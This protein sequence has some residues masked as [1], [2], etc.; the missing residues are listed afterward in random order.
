MSTGFYLLD[1]PNP[2]G[3]NYYTS[4]NGPILAQI[5]HITAGLQDLELVDPDSSAERTA[6]YAATTTRDVSW[7]S[8]S[9]TDGFLR[10]LPP[11]Y[12]AWQCI[13]YNSITL[14]HEISKA[15][16]D[17]RK[18][19]PTWILRTLT[20]AANA[21]RPDLTKYR[22]PIRKATRAELDR[23]RATDGPP[24]GLI[25]HHELDP[26]RRSDPGWIGPAG[27][28]VDTFPWGLFFSILRNE[29]DV[30][31]SDVWKY[32]VRNDK[33]GIV[34]SAED[35]LVDVEG[36]V[37]DVQRELAELRQIVEARL[38]VQG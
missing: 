18:M 7:H 22:I 11:S 25:S 3:P 26:D 38:P 4:R 17:W 2:S 1:H 30:S 5:M 19:S 28:Q 21:V 34:M 9:D 24:V 36:R 32:P 10:L 33:T 20:H 6:M 27:A 31:A 8:G 12:T 13:G 16:T 15:D 37:A 35:R 29:D 23:A 14:G